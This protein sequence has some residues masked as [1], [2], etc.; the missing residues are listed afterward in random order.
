MKEHEVQ[1]PELLDIMIH[2]I[3]LIDDT[4]LNAHLYQ[5][6]MHVLE[7]IVGLMSGT[8]LVWKEI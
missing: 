8:E 4:V 5:N 1:M 2:A 3:G 7:C 6:L